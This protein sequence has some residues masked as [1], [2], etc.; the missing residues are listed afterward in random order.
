MWIARDKSGYLC[1][2]NEKPRKDEVEHIFENK[3]ELLHIDNDEFPEITWENSPVEITTTSFEDIWKQ[4]R[5]EIAKDTMCALIIND[6]LPKV[7]PA[8]KV[9]KLAVAYADELIK[10]LK[11]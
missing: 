10:E 9:E 5:Y 1:I 7:T 6:N 8:L 4:R 2:Y 11:K 3:D